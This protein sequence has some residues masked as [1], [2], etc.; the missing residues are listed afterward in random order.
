[1][2]NS[3]LILILLL[4]GPKLSI[5]SQTFS[6]IATGNYNY[7]AVA[8][9]ISS[10]VTTTGPIDGSNYIMYSAAYGASFSISNGLPNNG[11]ISSGTYTYQLQTYSL[12]NMCFLMAG[13]T[14]SII[15][16][17][18]A[19]YAGLS[20]L[21]F[22]TEGNGSMNV[23]VRFTDNS[24]QV[25]SNQGLTDWF[26]TGNSIIS[27]F[28][29]ANRS[30]G[31]PAN[32][33]GNPKMFNL[34]LVINCANR[35][36]NIQNIK[37]QN[38][39]TNARNCIMAVSGAAAPAFTTTTNAV[40]CAGGTNGSALITPQGGIAPFS[41]TWS[42]VPPQNSASAASLAVGVYSYTATDAALCPMNGTVSITQ[43]LVPEPS[44]TVTSNF[45]TVCAG[46]P[47]QLSSS[48]AVTFTW[49]TGANSPTISAN[50][51]VNSI[52]T[53]SGKT[54]VNC[55][56]TGSVSIT[57]N[58]LPQISF[59]TPAS[60]C[61]NDP[62]I[63]LN[64]TPAGG[65][66]SGLGVTFGSFY[67][68]IAGAGS[69]TVSYT[70]SDL[71]NCTSSATNTIFVNPLPAI[72]F[73]VSA[74]SLCG[75]SPTLMLNALPVGG[76][77]NG[78]GVN[79]N[80]YT[81]TVAG[82]GNHTVSYTFTDANNCTA[83]GISTATINP[84][85]VVSY[86]T[87]KK[88]YCV[89]NPSLMLNA[90]P[91]GGTFSGAGVSANGAFSPA[92]AGVGTHPISY[93]YTDANNCTGTSVISMTVSACTGIN[94]INSNSDLVLVYPNPSK[95][96]FTLKA[97][98]ALNLVLSNQLGQILKSIELNTWN[99]FEV[100]IDDLSAGMYF[101]FDQNLSSGIKQK[102]IVSK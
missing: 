62:Q 48:G 52:Y 28:D 73:T 93:S 89:F 12:N 19:A 75:N 37:F 15:F 31:T 94:E 38:T 17:T 70:Y 57:V 99:N 22:S 47:I 6:P 39:S 64:A 26:G 16:T 20:L 65:T 34:D 56:R 29:R 79:G 7:D 77:Y 45:Y 32:I 100:N 4:I 14:D 54:S 30:S 49:N 90:S 46:S 76:T 53:V 33:T 44:L 41:Y 8:E 67:P 40:T 98:T 55:L 25:F 60:M 63:I 68:N 85:P 69:H 61:L 42:T 21:C 83:T 1:M 80:I 2:K 9:A 59:T 81:P 88:L 10:T 86:L 3:V 43:S 72:S 18:P 23:T 71:N 92:T 24:T 87:T 91:S 5:H 50:P 78:L 74:T 66:Y 11:L 13:N 36:K 35:S 82:V 84:V 51:T 102:I 58:A 96:S 97:E 101:I 95:G 27:G